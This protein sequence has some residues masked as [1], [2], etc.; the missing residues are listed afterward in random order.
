MTNDQLR[1]IR[2]RLRDGHQQLFRLQRLQIVALKDALDSL[3]KSHDELVA[4][5]EADNDLED[6][7]EP[8]A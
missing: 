3:F 7:T 8:P 2:R 1:A 5:M 6:L 4:L